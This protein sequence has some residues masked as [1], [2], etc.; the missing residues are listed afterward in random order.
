MCVISFEKMA[1]TSSRVTTRS[2]VQCFASVFTGVSV[3]GDPLEG[4]QVALAH[5]QGRQR[6]QTLPDRRHEERFA[7]QAGAAAQIQ[8]LPRRWPLLRSIVISNVRI[9]L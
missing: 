1:S 8:H 5:V 3:D 2:R 9:R 6:Q 4:A 7:H